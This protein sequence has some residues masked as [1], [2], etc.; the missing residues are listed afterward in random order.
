MPGTR[1]RNRRSVPRWYKKSNQPVPSQG[2][3]RGK[4]RQNADDIAQ[5]DAHHHTENA[6]D[7]AQNYRFQQKLQQDVSLLCAQRFPNSDL[8]RPLGHRDKHN[9]HNADAGNDQGHNADNERA[10]FY[11]GCRLVERFDIAVVGKNGKIIF[12]ARLE[13]SFFAHHGTGFSNRV[14]QQFG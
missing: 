5:S 2:N 7:I 13:P 8:A 10:D 11:S 4:V 1:A 6:T 12:L 9:V 3:G 14:L